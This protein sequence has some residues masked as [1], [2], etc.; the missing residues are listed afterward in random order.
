MG[1]EKVA[2]EHFNN[3]QAFLSQEFYINI[4][5]ETFSWFQQASVSP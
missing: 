5:V 2:M 3:M 1:S 4:F